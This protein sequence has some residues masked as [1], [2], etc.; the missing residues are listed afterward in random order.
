MAY[1]MIRASLS[2]ESW[3]ALVANPQDRSIPA[4]QLCEQHGSKLHSYFF[5]LGEHDVVAIIEA[6]DDKMIMAFNAAVASSGS[7]TS[8]QATALVTTS[9]VVEA[10][11]K[12][13]EVAGT[14]QPPAA[15]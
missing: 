7:V 3:K 9:E 10:M 2:A 4:A 11:R 12:A 8:T 6:D 15:G 5:A 1:Y 14:Y 13:G